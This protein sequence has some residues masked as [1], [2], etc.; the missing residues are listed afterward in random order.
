M[1]KITI[2]PEEPCLIPVSYPSNP[3]T[4]YGKDYADIEEVVMC[5]KKKASE[6]DDAYL[7]LY[8]KD[9]DGGGAETGDVLIDEANNTFTMNKG[10]DDIVE[11]GTYNMYIGVRVT[12]LTKFIWLRVK[13]EDS[14]DVVTDGI[15][16]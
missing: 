15:Q 10:E 2:Y 4:I 1:S 13:K 6:L 11:A 14:I 9:G 8:W 3:L 7:R 5:F 12:G 16:Q